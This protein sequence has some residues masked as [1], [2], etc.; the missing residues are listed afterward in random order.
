MGETIYDYQ[1]NGTMGRQVAYNIDNEIYGP[2]DPD[3]D[4]GNADGVGDITLNDIEYL[5]MFHYFGG[6]P[7]DPLCN[8]DANGD[9]DRWSCRHTVYS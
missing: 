8:G 3:C 6:P 2:Y 5:I 7:P 4:W 1:H 9:C